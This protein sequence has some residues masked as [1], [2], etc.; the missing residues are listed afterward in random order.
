[1]TR[2]TR[3][4]IESIRAVA[5]DLEGLVAAAIDGRLEDKEIGNIERALYLVQDTHDEVLARL[6]SA[7]EDG[8]K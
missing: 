1:M 2:Q 3:Q 7:D 4:L 6:K 5:W 8:P